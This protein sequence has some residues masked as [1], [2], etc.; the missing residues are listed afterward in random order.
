MTVVRKMLAPTKMNRTDLMIAF[1][2]FLAVSLCCPVLIAIDDEDSDLPPVILPGVDSKNGSG[3]FSTSGNG[4]L[5]QVHGTSGSASAGEIQAE[6]E[7]PQYLKI[8]FNANHNKPVRVD[9]C[10]EISGLRTSCGG[11]NVIITGARNRGGSSEADITVSAPQSYLLDIF[12][13]GETRTESFVAL[14]GLRMTTT[15]SK[16]SSELF[17]LDVNSGA[18]AVDGMVCVILAEP[19]TLGSVKT[20]HTLGNSGGVIKT[21]VAN[22]G[23]LDLTELIEAMDASGYYNDYFSFGAVQYGFDAGGN[24]V[25]ITNVVVTAHP[26]NGTEYPIEIQAYTLD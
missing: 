8:A 4:G 6:G 7:V 19:G 26:F 16:I 1:A 24:V 14:P 11:D 18:D 21:Y 13:D 2:I 20:I 15:L 12:V 9:D 17:Q 5:V 22:G 25:S 3:T 23:Q 10:G